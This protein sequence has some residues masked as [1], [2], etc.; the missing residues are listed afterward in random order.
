MGQIPIGANLR[1]TV[2]L[3]K[4]AKFFLYSQI[5]DV[6]NCLIFPGLRTLFYSHSLPQKHEGQQSVQPKNNIFM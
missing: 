6:D 3:R 4:M 5:P 2:F 1:A